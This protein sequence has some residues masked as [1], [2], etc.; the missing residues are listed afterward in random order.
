MPGPRPA[1]LLQRPGPGPLGTP[2]TSMHTSRRPR[3][4]LAPASVS[5][6]VTRQGVTGRP[7][8]GQAPY[9]PAWDRKPSYRRGRELRVLPRERRSLGRELLATQRVTPRVDR[10]RDRVAVCLSPLP[11][12]GALGSPE[13]LE[14][15]S[16]RWEARTLP[17]FMAG[18]GPT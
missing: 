2:S 18:S 1:C 17:S 16:R 12:L 15:L 9:Y 13:L 4:S 10:Q 8:M 7:E 3:V 6:C 11:Q 5:F 14:S